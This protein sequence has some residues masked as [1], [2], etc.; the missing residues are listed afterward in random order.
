MEFLEKILKQ[1]K[2]KENKE[3]SSNTIKKKV[4]DEFDMLISESSIKISQ[5]ELQSI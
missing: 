1:D 2:E 5:E 4:K 3:Q